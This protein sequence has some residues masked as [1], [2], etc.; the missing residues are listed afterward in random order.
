MKTLTPL[1]KLLSKAQIVFN[2]YIRLRDKDK[3][4]I[5]CGGEVQEAGH[6]YSQGHH[7]AVRY[8]EIN[9]N[10]QCTRCNRWLHGNLINYRKGLVKRYGENEV[11]K[12]DLHVDLKK[13]FKWSR[14]ELEEL[15]KHYN[16]KI[17]SL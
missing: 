4:C 6:Y 2:K 11:N 15:I 17:K 13:G 5:S 10:G 14:I 8:S 12:L 3:G 16:E 9:T 1:P 7:S